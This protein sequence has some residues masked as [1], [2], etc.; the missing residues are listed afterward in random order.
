MKVRE[1]LCS[2]RFAPPP[3]LAR[4]GDDELTALEGLLRKIEVGRS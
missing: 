4:L 2:E 1:S 3:E